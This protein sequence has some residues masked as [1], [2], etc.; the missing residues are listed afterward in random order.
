M[1][2]CNRPDQSLKYV[3]S[4]MGGNSVSLQSTICQ[5]RLWHCLQTASS[6]PGNCFKM[7]KKLVTPIIL[8]TCFNGVVETG[9]GASV[10]SKSSFNY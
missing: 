10:F 9:R 4:G 8:Y 7:H 5:V 1:A 2:V 3:H 6:G